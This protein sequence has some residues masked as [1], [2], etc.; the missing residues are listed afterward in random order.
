[1][2]QDRRK[3]YQ[4]VSRAGLLIYLF[5]GTHEPYRI[6]VSPEL[7]YTFNHRIAAAGIARRENM[8][9]SEFLASSRFRYQHLRPV[10][11][12]RQM[13][14]KKPRWCWRANLFRA[15]ATAAD[16][17]WRT[18]ASAE[19]DTSRISRAVPLAGICRRYR[20]ARRGA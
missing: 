11:A 1:M 3:R 13:S 20:C 8:N 16:F 18:A 4:S 19:H 10:L 17:A 12:C 2:R 6:I 9:A 5:V 15:G 14:D 7:G